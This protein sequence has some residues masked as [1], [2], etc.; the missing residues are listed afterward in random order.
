MNHVPLKDPS[1]F[2][3]NE[4]GELAHPFRCTRCGR[5]AVPGGQMGVF[6]R[7]KCT[8][9]NIANTGSWFRRFTGYRNM[10]RGDVSLGP[11]RIPFLVRAVMDIGVCLIGGIAVLLALVPVF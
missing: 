10:R 7:E 3:R 4:F 11:V 6:V 1:V 2:K 5:T 8:P 9:S